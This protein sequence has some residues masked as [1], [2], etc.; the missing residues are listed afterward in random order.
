MASNLIKQHCEK[1]HQ[2][3]LKDI[4]AKL[5]VSYH[6]LYKAAQKGAIRYTRVSNRFIVVDESEEANCIELA[7]KRGWIE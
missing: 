7:K 3:E 6:N 2:I 4:A 5:N 1:N